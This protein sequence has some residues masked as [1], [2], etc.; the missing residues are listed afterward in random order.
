M[1]GL[2][3]H[4]GMRASG[5]TLLTLLANHVVDVVLTRTKEQMVW[6]DA[7]RIVAAVAHEHPIR[8]RTVRHFPANAMGQEH[9]AGP[10][11]ATE[12]PVAVLIAAGGPK[13][14]A[15]RAIH[16]GPE[17]VLVGG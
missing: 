2:F 6:V 8:D 10:T 16:F 12:L 15:A 11:A 13:P 7:R 4:L 5:A 17:S 1:D 9:P 14:T 3:G